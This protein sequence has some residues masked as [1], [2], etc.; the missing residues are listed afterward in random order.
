MCFSNFYFD[1]SLNSFTD[2]CLLLLKQLA[3]KN[4]YVLGCLI[5][6]NNNL[7]TVIQSAIIEN[8][9]KLTDTPDFIY[10]VSKCILNSTAIE[11]EDVKFVDE[12]V[13]FLET[14]GLLF[15]EKISSHIL[16]EIASPDMLLESS[17]SGLAV[18]IM[19]HQ[20]LLSE[21]YLVISPILR[22]FIFNLVYSQNYYLKCQLQNENGVVSFFVLY[23]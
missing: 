18:Q 23:F 21:F 17:G 13:K 19:F 14:V 4:F 10:L 9:D 22:V 7:R 3:S 16:I 11:N 6:C 20:K 2:S 15:W 1:N 12:D 8:L 5:D